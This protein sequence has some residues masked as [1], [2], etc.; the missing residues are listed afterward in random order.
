MPHEPDRPPT[1][2]APQRP[3]PGIADRARQEAERRTV[4]HRKPG[5]ASA[6]DDAQRPD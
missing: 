4:G 1:A 5:Q 3:I 2:P 6:R